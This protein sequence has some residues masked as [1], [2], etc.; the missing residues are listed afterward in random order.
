VAPGAGVANDS[1]L[2]K[3]FDLAGPRV[4]VVQYFM[5]ES[6]LITYAL[7]GQRVG[8]D[9]Y[10]LR[11]KCVPASLAG[12]AGDQYTCTGFTVQMG[13]APEVPL[14]VLKDWTYIFKTT[15]TGMD[16]KGQVFGIDH[17]KFNDLRD[18]KGQVIPPEKAYHVYNAFIDFHAFCNVFA[19]RTP[20]GGGI[21]DLTVIGQK[22]VHAAA[23]TEPPVNVGSHVSEGSTFKNGEVTL[24]FKGLSWV[25]G[26]ACAIVEYDSGESSFQ[27][28]THPMPNMEIKS[29]GS[30][31]YKGDIF[32]DLK[33]NWV[34]KATMDELVV[35]ETILPMAPH[36][37]N[38]VVER[39]II[40]RNID[41][42]DFSV[43]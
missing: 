40:I 30:S 19:E 21:Q 25:D 26:T 35:T 16:E 8:T 14:P 28:I 4:Q 24:A 10:R 37:V 33:T 3:S 32:I 18:A 9:V 2:A 34:R 43:K 31:H 41:E 1:M 36:K 39:N 17:A 42:T 7:N 22:V 23:F 38:M 13:N 11:L 15:T 5:M 6:R 29:V 27:M 20:A 12:T